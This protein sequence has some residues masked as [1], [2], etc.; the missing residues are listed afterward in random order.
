MDI[1]HFFKMSDRKSKCG[2]AGAFT[3]ILLGFFYVLLPLI[4]NVTG[5]DDSWGTWHLFGADN[6]AQSVSFVLD[7]NDN[8]I[9]D[10]QGRWRFMTGDNAAWAAPYFDDS[11]WDTLVVPSKWEDQGYADYDGFAWYRRHFQLSTEASSQALYAIM[12]RIDDIDEV[13][14]NGHKI[15]GIGSYPP[16]VLA[17]WGS[18]RTYAIPSDILNFDG[19]NVIAVRVYD[20]RMGGGIYDSKIGVYHSELVQPLLSLGGVWEFRKGHDPNWKNNESD[21]TGF[22]SVFI[23]HYWESVVGPY[24]GHAWYRKQFGPL[25]MAEDTTLVLLLG[26]IDDVDET[27]ING[28]SIGRTGDESTSQQENFYRQYRAYEFS[29][30]LLAH[31]N[32]I[33][34]HVY[35][36]GQGGGMYSGPIAL[37]T[38]TDYLLLKKQLAEKTGL[39]WDKTTDW[40]LGRD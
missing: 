30:T 22:L 35:D 24:N 7:D 31:D 15:G 20:V 16:N 26:Q 29:S 5:R 34:V 19:D 10:L 17:A 21:N 13:F 39:S 9:V 36:G 18:E 4:S 1:K 25:P 23:P 32:R 2:N 11:A 40:L 33:A 27:F 37:L 14:I 12:G 8:K 6:A 3:A 28:V 38:K